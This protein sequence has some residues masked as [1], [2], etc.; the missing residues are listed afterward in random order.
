[1]SAYTKQTA[2][3]L[4][5]EVESALRLLDRETTKCQSNMPLFDTEDEKSPC[6]YS[7]PT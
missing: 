3:E 2:I 6:I 4:A 1:M 5:I 7:V